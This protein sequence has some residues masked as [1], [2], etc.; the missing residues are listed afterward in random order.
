MLRI[1]RSFDQEGLEYYRL[2]K[3]TVRPLDHQDAEALRQRF[4]LEED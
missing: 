4:E 2:K 1:L 3:D